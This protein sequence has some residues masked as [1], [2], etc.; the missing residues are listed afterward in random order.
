[1]NTIDK[2]A[3][4]QPGE[5]QPLF[6]VVDWLPP[7]FGAVGQ[8]ALIYAEK[9]A[10]AGR[11]I[12]LV[13]LT[14]GEAS[15]S[16]Q[17]FPGG[18]LLRI[19]RIAASSYNKSSRLKRL[20]WALQTNCRLVFQIIRNPESYRA[21]V[22]FTGSPPFML[23]LAFGAKLFRRTTLIYRITDFFPEVIVADSGKS[24]MLLRALQQLIWILRRK[25]DGFQVLG[26]DQRRLL[27][28]GGIAPEKILL[29]RDMSPIAVTGQE[30]PAQLPPHLVSRPVIV[31]SGNYG[32]AHEADTVVQGLSEHYH[33]NP[34][35]RFSLWLNASGAKA[36]A[37]EQRLRASNIGVALT[38]PVPLEQLPAVLAAADVHLITL[39]PEFCGIVLPSKVYAC[40]ASRRPIL[41]V[42]PK[43]S[44]VHLLCS[45]ANNIA[46]E[47]VDPGDVAGFANALDRLALTAQRSQDAR[48][49]R[50]T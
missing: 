37:I 49:R 43:D 14:S 24:S 40:I 7:D 10:A 38:P 42:G 26:E 34:I 44:D 46:Y 1:M 12:E 8:Y 27:L 21:E 45:Q 23:L 29:L 6:Y 33:R 11:H 13:G 48:S 35:N 50:A 30:I 4:S 25:V 28:K 41:Y 15:I 5:L 2:P 31:Y 20:L 32:V 22:L 16:E 19:T 17:H 9:C 47:Q 36:E 18:G 3:A 39:R